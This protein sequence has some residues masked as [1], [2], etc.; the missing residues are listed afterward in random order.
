[1]K[2]IRDNVWG[3]IPVS[4]IALRWIDTEEFQRLHNIRQTGLAYKVFPT[5]TSTRFV[6]SLGVYHL[7]QTLL[8]SICRHQPNVAEDLGGEK[9]EWI[10]LAGLLHD[11]GH[12]PFSHLFDD[13]LQKKGVAARWSAHENRALDMISQMNQKYRIMSDDAISFIQSMI[14]PSHETQR[15]YSHLIHN[16][17]SGVDVDKMD[18]LVR[19]NQQFGLCMSVDVM[20][21]LNNCRVVDD[22][23]CFCDKVQDE[24]WSLFLIR[25]RLHSTIYRH[26]RTGKFEKEVNNI[27]DKMEETER[28]QERI[29]QQD[30]DTFLKWTDPYILFHADPVRRHEFHT[31]TSPIINP[32]ERMFYI[33]DQFSKL[34]NLWFYHRNQLSQKFHLTFPSIH[35]PFAIPVH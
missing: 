31:R 33:D 27:L 35:C 4:D 10:C 11:I 18:Y 34:K 25:H 19:D 2:I 16:P 32:K 23:L 28:F 29:Y 26:P 7:L 5:A 24:I 20:R 6:H 21:I 17:I 22:T 9:K 14:V 15:W 8:G 1:M 13:Y 30:T 12:G 3:D